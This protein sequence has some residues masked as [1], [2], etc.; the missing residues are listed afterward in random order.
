MESGYDSGETFSAQ[1]QCS[2]WD[3][4]TRLTQRKA[5]SVLPLRHNAVQDAG[6]AVSSSSCIMIPPLPDQRQPEPLTGLWD[7]PIGSDRRCQNES[8]RAACTSGHFHLL[9]HTAVIKDMQSSL[10]I[11]KHPKHNSMRQPKHSD[12][13]TT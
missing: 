12:P 7:R 5:S 8:K 4:V 10:A 9:P 13:C 1:L 6:T 3:R 11:K 2:Q